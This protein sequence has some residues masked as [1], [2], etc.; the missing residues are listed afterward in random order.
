MSTGVVGIAR[1]T[2]ATAPLATAITAS[3]RHAASSAAAAAD[4]SEEPPVSRTS[5]TR[6]RP[7]TN[8]ARSSTGSVYWRVLATDASPGASSATR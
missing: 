6:L 2:A 4:R 8:P 1:R 5:S 3:G 7:S